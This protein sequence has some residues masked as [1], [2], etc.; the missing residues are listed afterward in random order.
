MVGI[1]TG[2][3]DALVF[4]TGVAVGTWG[5]GEATPWIAGFLNA[6]S[7]GP[8]RLPKALHLPEGVVV[9]GVVL[10]AAAGFVG[11]HAIEKR[12]ASRPQR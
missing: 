11:A 7:R 5:M 2:R 4:L 3:L 9:A 8:L 6:G 12:F 10:L 1:A